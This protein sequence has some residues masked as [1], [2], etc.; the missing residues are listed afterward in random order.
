MV[1]HLLHVVQTG[2]G[3]HPGSNPMDTGDFFPWVKRQGREDDHSSPA[4]AEVKEMWIYT[5][6]PPYAFMA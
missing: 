4:S 1:K 2:S 6:T 3:A 5:T